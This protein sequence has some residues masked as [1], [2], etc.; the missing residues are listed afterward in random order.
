MTAMRV[1]INPAIVQ[2]Y[3]KGHVSL[4]EVGPNTG[5]HPNPVIPASTSTS[6]AAR[7]IDF[8]FIAGRLYL[9]WPAAA[10]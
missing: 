5:R 8:Y 4:E 6:E 2:D 1:T 10:K 9:I 3:P 7:Q